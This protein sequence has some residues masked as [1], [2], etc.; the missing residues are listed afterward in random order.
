M[1]QTATSG[2][3]LRIWAVVSAAAV[4]ATRHQTRKNPC[5]RDRALQLTGPLVGRL[6]L[7]VFPRPGLRT[8]YLRRTQGEWEVATQD[9]GDSAFWLAVIQGLLPEGLRVWLQA[10]SEEAEDIRHWSPL[11]R[12]VEAVRRPET[13]T[14]SGLHH[15]HQLDRE[16]AQELVVS[17]PSRFPLVW[18]HDSP[19]VAK[20]FVWQLLLRRCA[21]RCQQDLLSAL[22]PQRAPQHPRPR[23]PSAHSLTH[24]PNPPPSSK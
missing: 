21:H 18:R 14:H 12:E 2:C 13:L 24:H 15:P 11:K 19:A 17:T 3:T 7:V 23:L 6:F 22:D 16:E 8:L 9:K 20:V 1:P 5:R 10:A 4:E